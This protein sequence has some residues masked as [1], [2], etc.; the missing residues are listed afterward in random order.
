M[1]LASLWR[2]INKCLPHYRS[3]VWVRLGAVHTSKQC[4]LYAHSSSWGWA[5]IEAMPS[6]CPQLLTL[7]RKLNKQTSLF[8]ELKFPVSLAMT[9]QNHDSW[10]SPKS[11]TWRMIHLHKR[12]ACSWYPSGRTNHNASSWLGA[13]WSNSNLWCSKL[14]S[15]TQTFFSC[16]SLDADYVFRQINIYEGWLISKVSSCIK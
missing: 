13:F 7:H 6:L 14:C 8:C 3:S 1:K 9:K 15:K 10:K 12:V 11:K 2:V 5:H 16:S 4:P